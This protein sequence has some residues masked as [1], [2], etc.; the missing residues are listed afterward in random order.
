MP[1]PPQGFKGISFADIL[2][3]YYRKISLFAGIIEINTCNMSNRGSNNDSSNK[4]RKNKEE[5]EQVATSD[6]HRREKKKKK[7]TEDL[8]KEQK[9][10]PLLHISPE[11]KVDVAKI[12]EEV[13][14]EEKQV[15]NTIY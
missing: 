11:E 10:E 3:R 8:T 12:K 2:M 7:M 4:K 5:K 1:E 15:I 13:M 9:R 6:L 14:S